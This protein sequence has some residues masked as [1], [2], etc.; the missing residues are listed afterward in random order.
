MKKSPKK[1][2][3][4]DDRHAELVRALLKAAMLR[5][6]DPGDYA[7]K[8]AALKDAAALAAHAIKHRNREPPELHPSIASYVNS[9]IDASI[10]SN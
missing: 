10:D 8:M 3:A 6:G 2:A 1:K 4:P 9:L 5:P 7:G